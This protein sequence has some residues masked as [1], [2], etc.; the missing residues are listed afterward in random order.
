MKHK[1]FL[2]IV[3]LTLILPAKG[4]AQ[5]KVAS[6]DLLAIEL[7]PDYDRASVLVLITGTLPA[8]TKLPA[9]V[10]LPFPE[11]AQL[12]AVARIDSTDGI[13]KDDISSSLSHGELTFITPDLRFRV[14]YYLLYTVNNNQRTF[15]FNWLADLSVNELQLR[16]Q[17]PTSASSLSTEPAPVNVFGGEDGFTYHAFPSQ[18]VPAGKS[19]SVQVDYT[20]T[21]A[22]LSAESLTPSSERVQEPKLP[23][24]LKT[25]A[26][27][28]WPIV[29]VVVICIIIVIV[30]VRKI[31]TGRAGPDRPITSHEKSKKRSRANF[32]SNCG[33]PKDKDDR[34]CRKCGTAL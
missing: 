4:F 30:F 13:M 28:N 18:A 34:F 8:D 21:M 24:T 23:S 25:A 20:M 3:L 2:L 9:S 32:C 33:S 5:D 14:E 16:V 17:Q 15:N 29:A 11:T 1:Y 22:K 7:W 31:T 19:I 27:V 6:I 12:N 10:T 26:G